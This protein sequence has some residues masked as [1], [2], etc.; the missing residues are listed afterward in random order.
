MLIMSNIHNTLIQMEHQKYLKIKE[1]TDFVNLKKQLVSLSYTL[2]VTLPPSAMLL[3]QFVN[4]LKNEFSDITEH[5]LSDAV[6][7]AMGGK[8]NI[9]IEP[10]NNFS[11]PYLSKILIAYQAWSK[12]QKILFPSQPE[13]KQIESGHRHELHQQWLNQKCE[14]IKKFFDT[15][16]YTL[17]DHGNP[18]YHHLDS[19]GLI[20]FTNERKK[21]FMAQARTELKKEYQSKGISQNPRE[22]KKIIESIEKEGQDTEGIVKAEAKRIA[23]K[24]FL[25]ECREMD[26]DIISEINQQSAIVRET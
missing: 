17:Q 26:Y 7:K 22:V 14:Q 20:T 25:T 21:E 16:E 18:F 11:I 5:D 1:M 9:N 15:G 19:C 8:L 6:S 2:G 10:F 13:H 3:E 4:L 23:L 12:Q 24:T